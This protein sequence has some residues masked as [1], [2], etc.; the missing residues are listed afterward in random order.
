[1]FFVGTTNR[2]S[3]QKHDDVDHK[4]D[5]GL[6]SPL[7]SSKHVTCDI[8]GSFVQTVFWISVDLRFSNYDRGITLPTRVCHRPYLGCT[9]CYLGF[10]L[11]LLVLS[12]S[13]STLTPTCILATFR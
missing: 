12:D 7:P 10:Y 8:T 2:S 13:L 1:M 5:A 6:Y 11:G 3:R 9:W 4:K